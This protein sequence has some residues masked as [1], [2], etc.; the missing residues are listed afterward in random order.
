M[1][2]ELLPLDDNLIAALSIRSQADK[3]YI[4]KKLIGL[5]NVINM[6]IE[7]YKYKQLF[8]LYYMPSD[9]TEVN[10]MREQYMGY[11]LQLTLNSNYYP[12]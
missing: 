8:Q 1:S 6:K 2:V 11:L 9:I 7:G 10:D 12:V 4:I 5:I 3:D